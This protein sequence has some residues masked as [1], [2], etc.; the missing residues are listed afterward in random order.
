VNGRRPPGETELQDSF[1]DAEKQTKEKLGKSARL[2]A[3]DSDSGKYR[4]EVLGETDHHVLQK[5]GP[6]SVVAH[7]RNLIPE[8]LSPGQSVAVNY[9]NLQAQIKPLKARE[10]IQ[11]LSR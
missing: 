7:P 2:Y 8:A 4:G 11:S 10:R 5:I 3:A 1:A 9:S 6:K